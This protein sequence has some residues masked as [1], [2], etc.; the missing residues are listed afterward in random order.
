MG[1]FF[2]GDQ[3]YTRR[4]QIQDE[5]VTPWT[6][7]LMDMRQPITIPEMTG[8]A[9]FLTCSLVSIAT[10]H[11]RENWTRCSNK[12]TFLGVYRQFERNICIRR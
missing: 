4:G 1:F 3:L 8:F 10:G 9:K 6:S 5:D 7:I 2:K 12:L 11:W